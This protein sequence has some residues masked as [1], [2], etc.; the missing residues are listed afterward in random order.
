VLTFEQVGDCSKISCQTRVCSPPFCSLAFGFGH[1]LCSQAALGAGE[2]G[3]FYLVIMEGA[4]RLEI[5]ANLEAM[6]T[7]FDALDLR[8]GATDAAMSKLAHAMQKTQDELL[9]S[10]LE[11]ATTNEEIVGA[12]RSLRT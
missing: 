1:T 4:V 10:K 8:A 3:Y 12:L 9:A 7:K 5:L 2:V 6:N 11:Q